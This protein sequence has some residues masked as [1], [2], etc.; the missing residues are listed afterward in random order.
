MEACALEQKS[1]R[2]SWLQRQEVEAAAA[3]EGL[4]NWQA[5][6]IWVWIIVHWN[7]TQWICIADV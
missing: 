3:A 4:V 1:P 5:G 6:F 2:D 7:I